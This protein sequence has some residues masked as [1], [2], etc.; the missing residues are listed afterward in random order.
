MEYVTSQAF[1]IGGIVY[2]IGVYEDGAGYMAFCDC[3]KCASHNMQS[4]RFANKGD[5]IRECEKLIQKH[6]AET[7]PA[8]VRRQ[9]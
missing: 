6:H 5:A 4:P 7:H 8:A 1:T 9:C 3:H 2:S